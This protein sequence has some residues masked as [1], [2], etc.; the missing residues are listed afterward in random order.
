MNTSRPRT[1]QLLKAGVVGAAAAALVNTTIYGIGRAADVTYAAARTSHGPD[2]IRLHHVV[3]LT[4]TTFGIGLVAAVVVNRVGRP[5]LRALA[6][7]AS[8]VAVTSVAMDV[9][10]PSTAPAKASLALM[11]LVTGA[12]YVA[13]LRTV[14]STRPASVIG[15]QDTPRRLAATAA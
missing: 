3:G 8:I 4:F 2:L 5:S 12:A 11:H 13:G 10:I 9:S 15:A 14:R 1:S 6:I 7:F